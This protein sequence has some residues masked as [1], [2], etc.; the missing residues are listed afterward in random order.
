MLCDPLPPPPDDVPVLPLDEETDL[1]PPDLLAQHTS[2]PACAGCHG[3]IDPVGKAFEHYTGIGVWRDAYHDETPV[4]ASTVLSGTPLDGDYE[5]AVDLAHALADSDAAATCYA[6][7]W[8]RFAH[9][10]SVETDDAASFDAVMDAFLG[11]EG[12]VMALTRAL[13][14]TDAFLYRPWAPPLEE[15]AP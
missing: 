10:R 3:L 7:Y 9:G 6:R 1:S 8:Y 14:T 11:A 2:D 4:D 15:D 12:E 5:D 13:V